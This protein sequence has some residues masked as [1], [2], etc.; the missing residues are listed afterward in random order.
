MPVGDRRGDQASDGQDDQ[1]VEPG[2]VAGCRTA[3]H[4]EQPALLEG[5]ASQVP[6]RNADH[7]DDHRFDPEHPAP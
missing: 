2:E 5:F 7:S 6:Q 3:G 1:H 4:C